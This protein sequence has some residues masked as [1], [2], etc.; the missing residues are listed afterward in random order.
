M[1]QKMKLPLRPLQRILLLKRSQ[2]KYL[3]ISRHF[4]LP[5]ILSLFG[6]LY[7]NA[8]VS[9]S[10]LKVQVRFHP[11]NDFVRLSEFF[12]GHENT[13]NYTI[14]RSQKERSGLYFYVPLEETKIQVEKIRSFKLSLIDSRNPIARNFEF[15][16]PSNGKRQK[17]IL[18]GITG[19]DWVEKDDRLIAW[20]IKI[21]GEDDKDFQ[22][23]MSS[24]WQH[25]N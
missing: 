1:P 2:A 20:E 17:K 21:L 23:A 4:G 13:G 14:L 19:D 3:Q 5:A 15:Q 25:S 18:L 9:N 8:N 12:T 16:M 22:V 7:V 11:A 10:P 24:L 6:L